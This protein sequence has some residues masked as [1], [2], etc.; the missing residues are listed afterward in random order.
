MQSE[1]QARAKRAARMATKSPGKPEKRRTAESSS[2]SDNTA[3]E[4]STSTVTVETK[5]AT[6]S[7]PRGNKDMIQRTQELSTNDPTP[8]HR[9]TLARKAIAK[10]DFLII[11]RIQEIE[12]TKKKSKQ[13]ERG[14]QHMK[15]KNKTD[16]HKTKRSICTAN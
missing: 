14:L 1:R 4:T 5:T 2:D 6:E 3:D 11:R 9:S 13:K 8:P 7:A 12:E 15:L 10:F 16:R